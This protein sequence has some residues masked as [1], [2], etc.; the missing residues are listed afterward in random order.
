MIEPVVEGAMQA[1]EVRDELPYNLS[2]LCELA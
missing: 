2:R 1:T